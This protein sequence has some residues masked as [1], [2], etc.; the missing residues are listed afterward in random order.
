MLDAYGAPSLL[1]GFIAATLSAV[2]A[3]RWMVAYLKTHGLALFGYYRV[4]LA[5]VVAALLLTGVM[6]SR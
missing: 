2:A 3:V 5:L 4:A 6:S 1:A